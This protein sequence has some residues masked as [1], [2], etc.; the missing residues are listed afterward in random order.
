MPMVAR[1][2]SYG[3]RRTPKTHSG[4]LP[5]MLEYFLIFIQ[6]VVGLL[7]IG[8]I[9]LQKSKSQGIGTAFGGGMGESLFGSQI[10]NVLT[11]ITVGLALV[12]M[13]NS[14][15]IT[16]I[17]SRRAQRDPSVTE[18]SVPQETPT[19]PAQ[20]PLSAPT[21]GAAAPGA[22]APL[23][24]PSDTIPAQ[25]DPTVAP[26]PDA[27]ADAAPPPVVTD[28]TETAAGAPEPDA[29]REEAPPPDAKP[30]PASE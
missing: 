16:Y 17:K 26:P 9:L 15:T 13:I 21:D 20:G 18:R 29:A 23:V 12:F 25:V 24:F 10:G 2:V 6:V 19:V 11:K 1:G 3:G 22:E 14:V 30:V 5:I 4:R 27:G 8:V 28:E 7:L